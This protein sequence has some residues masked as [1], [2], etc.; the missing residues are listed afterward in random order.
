M[1][2]PYPIDVQRFDRTDR[3]HAELARY[4]RWE[5][6]PQADVVAFLAETGARSTKARRNGA[7]RFAQGVRAIVRALRSLATARGSE[8]GKAEG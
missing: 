7:R 5:Y 2:G 8:A 4:V 6:G 3:Q 1:I